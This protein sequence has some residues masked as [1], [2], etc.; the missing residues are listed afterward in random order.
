MKRTLLLLLLA[1]CATTPPEPQ[2]FTTLCETVD[3][4]NSDDMVCECWE[5]G[6]PVEC[7]EGSGDGGTVLIEIR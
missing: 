5:G 2:P 1:A 4:P 7:P 3:Y 6:E